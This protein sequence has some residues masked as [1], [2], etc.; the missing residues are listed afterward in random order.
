M[1][2]PVILS[3]ASTVF[4]IYVEGLERNVARTYAG[5]ILSNVHRQTFP[6][7]CDAFFSHAEHALHFNVET[8]RYKGCPVVS[9]R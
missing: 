7:A 9:I 2:K 8:M 3:K 1:P 5:C 6:K 4:H